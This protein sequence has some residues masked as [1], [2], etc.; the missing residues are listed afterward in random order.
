MAIQDYT[1]FLGKRVGFMIPADLEPDVSITGVIVGVLN[2]AEG[3][4]CDGYSVLF[5][6]D[7]HQE[8]E[9]IDLGSYYGLH[10]ME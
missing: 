4:E 5:L 2:Y 7:G 1:S 10:T 3:Y 8:P 9:F 6:E